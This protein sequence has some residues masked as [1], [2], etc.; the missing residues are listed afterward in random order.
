MSVQ[1]T[2]SYWLWP[3]C[4]PRAVMHPATKWSELT[5]YYTTQLVT[6]PLVIVT[7]SRTLFGSVDQD[8]IGF[9]YSESTSDGGAV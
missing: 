8:R 9:I 1:E 4:A 3:L 6:Y 5:T 7:S 2:A